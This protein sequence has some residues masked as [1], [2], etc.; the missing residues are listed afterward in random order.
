MKSTV[1]FLSFE[2]GLGKI[3]PRQRRVEAIINFPKPTNKRKIQQWCGLAS[4]F[5]RYIPYF[6]DIVAELT[7]MLKKQSKF[8]WTDKAETTFLEIKSRMASHPI[9]RTPDYN[10]PFSLAC[11]SSHIAIAACLFKV[12][13]GLEHPICYISQK[14][15]KHQA[16]YSTTEKEALSLLTA[17]Q[18]FSV[19]FGSNPITVYTNH[20]PLRFL[21]KMQNHNQKLLRCRLQLQ[22]YNIT[23][24]HRK[25]SENILPDILSYILYE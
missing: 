14:L 9:S 24:C 18:R 12:I 5:Q 19:Y 20:H 23:I 10:L 7:T 22:E 17:V 1:D 8:E 25:G 13:D 15:N 21:Q 6:Q 11:D 3:E 2:V 16:T 4:Y